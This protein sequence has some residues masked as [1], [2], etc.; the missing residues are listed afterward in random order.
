MDKLLLALGHDTTNSVNA[1]KRAMNHI[2]ENYFTEENKS[3]GDYRALWENMRK[4]L[5]KLQLTLDQYNRAR[6]ILYKI[7]NDEKHSAN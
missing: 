2:E 3:N 1:I 4:E 6:K 7:N 5:E